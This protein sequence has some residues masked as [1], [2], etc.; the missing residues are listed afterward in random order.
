M[1]DSKF[2]PVND[3]RIPNITIQNWAS[4][5]ETYCRNY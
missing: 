1:G 3:L 5:F 2:L 4:V